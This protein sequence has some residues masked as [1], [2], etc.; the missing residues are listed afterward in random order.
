MPTPTNHSFT[1]S[2][3]LS[4]TITALDAFSLYFDNEVLDHILEQTN[5]YAEQTQRKGWVPLTRDELEA[6]IGMLILM[7]VNRMHQLQMYW[8]S[9]SFF[10]VNEIAKVMTYKRFQ[11]ICNCLHLN[12]ND[13]MPGYGDKDFDRAYKVRPLINMMNK[14]FQTEYNP[15]THVAVDESMILFKGRSSLKQYMPM[16]PKI[17]RGYK[18]WSLADSETGYL[19][20]FQLYEGKNAQKP[21][22]RTLGEHIVLS[23][24]DGVVPTGSQLFFDNFFSST[25]LLQELRDIGIFACGTF[26]TN[27]KDLP[28]EVKTDN[29]MDRGSYLWR[30]KRDVIAYQWRDTK[31]VHLMSNYHEPE[32]RVDVQRTLPNGKKIS[33]ECPQ[34]VKDYNAWM[35]GVDK[36]DQ[37]RNAYPA[38]R[39]SKRWWSRIFYFILDAA[40]VNAFI[41]AN[42]IENVGYL[43]FRLKLGRQLIAQRSF[44]KP[45]RTITAFKNKRG[46]SNGR[47]MTGVPDE[48]RFS[49]NTHHPSFTGTRRRCRWCSTSKREVRT[50]YM[51]KVCNVPL[52]ATCFAPFHK[53]V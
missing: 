29:K 12:D 21:L 37:K 47:A 41:Q 49:G 16:K 52:C 32:C 10:Y 48:S 5:L 9:D 36:F 4:P 6:Y 53:K 17:K 27:K 39:R 20:Q 22:D 3:R 34:V 19:L 14:K 2:Q 15:S 33:V 44:R 42:S 30:R 45:R 1:I 38:D 46:K 8:S 43:H 28:P 24:A 35:G 40:I 13:K 31:N 11:M 18:V 26:R 51:C 23:L 50:R 25:K 7:S